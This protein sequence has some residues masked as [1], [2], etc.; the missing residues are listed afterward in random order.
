[1]PS[2]SVR[3][4]C[5]AAF[6][7]DTSQAVD[8]LLD[9]A[10]VDYLVADYLSEITM[11]LLARVRQK[12]PEAGFV[13]DAIRVLAP[14]LK[15][16]HERRIRVVTNAGALNPG[17][18]ARAFREA[19]AEAG[20]PLRVAAVEGDD[21]MGQLADIHAGASRDMFTGEPLPARPM[22]MNAYLGARPIAAALAAGADVVVTGRAVDSSVVLGPLM[23]EFGWSDSDYDLLSAGTLAGH[24]VECGPQ[25]AGGNFTDWDSVP[26][27]DDMGF[28]IIECFPDGSAVVS[29]P[30]GTG[31]LVSPATIS[32]QI[33]YE[34]GDPGAYVMPDVVCDWRDVQLEQVGENRVRAWG[35]RGSQPPPTY[36][37]TATHA[38]GYRLMTTAMFAG[39][40][41][42]AKARRAGQ[43]LV[44]RGER[45]IAQ[46][47]HGPFSE[48]SIEVIGAGD[49][50][51]PDRR[52]DQATEAV[53]KIGVRHPERAALELFAL[54]YAPMALVAQGMTGFFGGRPRVAPAIAVYH[55]LVDKGSTPVQV[56]LDDTTLP[57][58]VAAGDA[59]VRVGTPALPDG[60]AGGGDGTGTATVAGGDFTVQLR[61]L[62]YGR[63]GD[64]GNQANIG[65]IARR[66][67]FVAVI[68]EQMTCER[69]ARFFAQYLTGGVQRW[70]MPGLHAIN[71]VLDGVLGG[72]GGTST[73]RY[74][75]QGKSFAAMLLEVPIAVP[76]AWEENGLLHR[77]SA[78]A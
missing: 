28:P 66:P 33:L 12:D 55:L 56:Q 20:V 54:E 77:G 67:E 75:P 74:D 34:I 45:L 72:K 13:P 17:A 43:A 52:H 62:A 40:D 71:F 68:R 3:L 60:I 65:I 24:I 47:G 27:W 70:E 44:S 5:W 51:G 53:V 69:V 19:A 63:S 18:C 48:T 46:A 42:A 76:A 26:G 25:C 37:V 9:R 15:E 32:E 50:Y 30:E 10:D 35:A 1:M 31:G 41:A 2:D 58:S 6:W 39:L 29:K 57:V 4:G 64:K 8:Q 11:A 78:A 49:T 14:R 38:D 23:H 22:T 16:I 7:G 36:K 61:R 21:L 59:D 73:L